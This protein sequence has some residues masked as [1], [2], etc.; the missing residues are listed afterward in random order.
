[1][2]VSESEQFAE[3]GFGFEVLDAKVPMAMASGNRPVNRPTDGNFEPDCLKDGTIP[4]YFRYGGN[5]TADAWEQS[6]SVDGFVNDLYELYSFLMTSLIEPK[7]NSSGMVLL[8]NV[9]QYLTRVYQSNVAN[10]EE[11]VKAFLEV[12][13]TEL[14]EWRGA[15]DLP[16]LDADQIKQQYLSVIA[17]QGENADT[18]QTTPTQIQVSSTNVQIQSPVLKAA[19][20][21]TQNNRGPTPPKSVQFKEKVDRYLYSAPSSTTTSNTETDQNATSGDASEAL[22]NKLSNVKLEV[23]IPGANPIPVGGG[24]DTD[25]VDGRRV[26]LTPTG[27]M[28]KAFQQLK[29]ADKPSQHSYPPPPSAVTASKSEEEKEDIPPDA[30][31]RP[32]ARPEEPK[33]LM[34]A[35]AK[36]ERAKIFKQQKEKER[37]ALADQQT[38]TNFLEGNLSSKPSATVPS[39]LDSANHYSF[40]DFNGTGIEDLLT[41]RVALG[42]LP[43]QD[44]F[45]EGL[46]L[47][48]PLGCSYDS[49]LGAG[50]TWL[51]ADSSNNRSAE[52]R[53]IGVE[54]GGKCRG[55]VMSVGGNLITLCKSIDDMNKF[56]VVQLDFDP[57]SRPENP[58][59]IAAYNDRVVFTD[60]ATQMIQV[61][62]ID[63]TDYENI[64]AQRLYVHK[65]KIEKKNGHFC[66]SYYEK[67]QVYQSVT[68]ERY[69]EGG[70]QFV[71]GVQMDRHYRVMVCDAQ[72]R[73]IQLFDDKL[74]FMYR[75]KLG[76]DMFYVSGF[77]INNNGETLLL[78]RSNN[79]AILTQLMPDKDVVEKK[80]YWTYHPRHNT[81]GGGPRQRNV[82]FNS[83]VENLEF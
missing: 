42:Q 50:G 20:S 35:E 79:Q 31:F 66:K 43:H 68:R 75:V 41:Y 74:N 17:S 37:T 55:L 81:G 48:R 34:S 33:I 70:F 13:A 71:S 77:F 30:P 49:K 14:N 32:F 59:F 8:Y 69:E 73:T 15:R 23:S 62:R 47:N 36:I 3:V 26:T 24:V 2:S 57:S 4:C 16:K 61:I 60:L 21:Q 22:I 82:S 27:F 78:G 54:L 67:S 65:K 7:L 45:S 44:N 9:M 80:Q 5:G 72:G 46:R 56:M 12:H 53:R 25:M 52:I 11:L 18:Q 40:A 29:Q 83:Q 64:K 6:M 76:F 28:T 58:S 51:I 39:T 1:M 63:D 10:D 19:I 38:S